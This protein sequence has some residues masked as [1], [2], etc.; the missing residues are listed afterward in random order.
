MLF[1]KLKTRKLKTYR[2]CQKPRNTKKLTRMRIQKKSLNKSKEVAPNQRALASPRKSLLSTKCFLAKRKEPLALA[3]SISY[4]LVNSFLFLTLYSS[5]RNFTS[6]KVVMHRLAFI[7][8]NINNIVSFMAQ[9]E[10][11]NATERYF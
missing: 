10:I 3:H 1:L 4:T 6:H 5:T 11:T 7:P 8:K 2:T 9:V